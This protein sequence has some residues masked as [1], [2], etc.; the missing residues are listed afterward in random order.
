MEK[1]YEIE[2]GEHKHEVIV[3]WVITH[4]CQESCG[5]CI[6]PNCSDEITDEKSHFE[7]Q[8]R[9]IKSGVTKMRYIG[10]EPLLVPHLSKL[11]I[12]AHKRGV[13][14]RISTN[15]RLLTRE[16]FDEIKD[17]VNSFA[18]PFE[19]LDDD[20]N[21]QIRNSNSHRV[22][23][24]DRIEMVKKA[25]NSIGVLVNTCVHREN[26]GKLMEL[27][28]Y[29]SEAGV[30]HW[31]LRRFVSTSGRGAVPNKDR[32]EITDE[33]FFEVVKQLNEAYPQLKI[34]GRMPEKLETRLMISP[35]G[36]LYRMTGSEK[37]FT[38]YGRLL[39][40]DKI[41][42]KDIYEQEHCN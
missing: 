18:F 39:N 2:D 25:N 28:K 30:D 35:Q 11:V 10:G 33:E 6:S 5:Y 15:A 8:D 27:G 16:K 32:F 29:L 34:S 31:K 24:Q 23:V 37:D 1:K 21:K 3:S 13:D 7:I 38:S 36:E 14:T 42:V 22:I 20:L 9:L 17:Y 19:S 41:N 26:I 12:D 40:K 4:R